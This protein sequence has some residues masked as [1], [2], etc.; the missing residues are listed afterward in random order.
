MK[1]N[2]LV[3]LSVAPQDFYSKKKER[4]F[5]IINFW[6]CDLFIQNICIKTKKEMMIPGAASQRSWIDHFYHSL[7]IYRHGR[8]L[9]ISLTQPLPS[10]KL[11]W[12]AWRIQVSEQ[13]AL[14]WRDRYLMKMD[15]EGFISRILEPI[16]TIL[17]LS[18]INLPLKLTFVN[19][20]KTTSANFFGHLPSFF[21][22]V[23]WLK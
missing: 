2:L 19:F 12:V 17:F 1:R 21:H 6:S 9:V 22:N 3:E 4:Y 7:W 18:K 14:L 8:D 16:L 15:Y 11:V 10:L 20:S 23:T 13:L 5:D